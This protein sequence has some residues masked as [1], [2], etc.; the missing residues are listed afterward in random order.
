MNKNINIA[1]VLLWVLLIV[2]LYFIIKY[3][4]SRRWLYYYGSKMDGPFA[5]PIIGS[6]HKFIGGQ[7]VFYKKVT[8]HLEK[9]PSIFKFWLGKDLIVVTSRPED[10]EIILNCCLEKPKFYAYGKKL[11][12]NCLFIAPVNNWKGKRKMVNPTFNSKIL[13]TFTETFGKHANRLVSVFEE[14]CGKE[15]SD[16]L[17]KI[18]KC[19]LDTVCEALFDVDCS[20]LYGQEDYIRKVIRIEDIIAIRSISVWLQVD[21]FWKMSSLCREMDKACAETFSFIKQ[22]INLKKLKQE[23]KNHPFTNF[24]LNLSKINAEIED[25]LQ[26]ILITGSESTA[27]TVGMTLIVLGIHPEVQRKIS[28]ELDLIFDHDE[29]DPTF[30]DIN[31]MQY[32]ECV[33]KETLRIFPIAPIIMRSIDQDIKLEQC[34]FPAGSMAFI[35]IHHIGKKPEFWKDPNKFD[36]DRFLPENNTNQHRC[37]FIPFSYGP[38]NCVGMKYGMMSMKVLLAAILRKYT[39]K[40]SQYKSLEDIELIFGMLAKPKHGYKIKLEKKYSTLSN[41]N[42]MSEIVNILSA[43]TWIFSVFVL[44]FIIQYNW[45]RRWLYY[46]GSKINGPFGWP[47]IGSAHY[48]MGG[49]KVFHKKIT[50]TLELQPSFFKFWLGND[51]LVVT[52]NPKDVEFVLNTCFEKPKFYQKYSY[53][54]IRNGLLTAPENI[55]RNRRKI[56]N[57][58]FNPKVLNSF[59][60]IFARHANNLVDGFEEN[61]GKESFDAF[62]T[63]FR[64]TLDM[65]CETF[66]D[67]DSTLLQ[68]QDNYIRNIMR[69]ENLIAIRTCSTWFHIDFI[70]ETSSLS[71][72]MDKACTEMFSFIQQIIQFKK[73]NEVVTTENSCKEKQFLNHLLNCNKIDDSAILEELQNIMITGSETTAITTGIVLIVLG[74]LPEIQSKIMDELESVFGTDDR[75]PT[76]E[77]INNLEYLERVI[78]ETLRLFPTKPLIAR[79][80]D[81]EI[82]LNSHTIPAGSI[83][84][85]PICHI[86][87]KAEFWNDPNKFDPDRFLP[88]N[89]SKRHRCSFIPFSYGHRNCLGLK[90]GM[91]SM[92]VVLLT[93]LRKYTIKASEYQKLEDV[94]LIYSMVT[95][96]TLGCKIKLEK[97]NVK[98][99]SK[100]SPI[101]NC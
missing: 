4:W 94:E 36:P 17:L 67:V 97:K 8:D 64:C 65:A 60:E 101:N 15:T 25:E 69:V 75:K 81:K 87:K 84:V 96:P 56:I 62:Y 27:L 42:T 91:M 83:V 77:D 90:Y 82:K 99:E 50:K 28:D 63:L 76:L 72:Q 19:T 45:S 3:N 13:S 38:R 29:R 57:P 70:W 66:A 21:I 78:K 7:E 44:C 46:Y 24:L 92:K 33:I 35:P 59:M 86:H 73:I 10:V 58:T 23:D 32:L 71:R 54:M 12:R 41:S 40:P 2:I 11:L 20:L 34:T 14:E 9:Y 88:E 51:L 100:R 5:W 39:I 93:I 55:W 49:Q 22:I 61:C 74:I 85:I 52:S 98:G 18:F 53:K 16:V 47:I 48:L 37:T 89:N 6:A 26:N 1:S 68:G 30:E 80:V 31:K 79:L 95:K 43:L